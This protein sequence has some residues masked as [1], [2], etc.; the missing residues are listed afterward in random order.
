MWEM[1]LT[2]FNNAREEERFANVGHNPNFQHLLLKIAA[3][4]ESCK[5]ALWFADSFNLDLLKITFQV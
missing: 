5:T 2:K 3:L 4:H 1:V